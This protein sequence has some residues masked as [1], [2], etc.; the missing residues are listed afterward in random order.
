M[1]NRHY[2]N[3]LTLNL[4][5]LKMEFDKNKKEKPPKGASNAEKH[6]FEK[7]RR[8]RSNDIKIAMRKMKEF[9][10]FLVPV[11]FRELGH[12]QKT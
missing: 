10:Q 2:A 11:E 3:P 4:R 7:K 8:N 12:P 1:E 5:A 9:E 6:A